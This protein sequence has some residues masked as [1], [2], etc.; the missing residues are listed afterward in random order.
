MPASLPRPA[1][2]TPGPEGAAA[3]LRPEQG[4]SSQVTSCSVA[5]SQPAVLDPGCTL[6]SVEKV[7]WKKILI[8]RATGRRHQNLW[9]WDL[10]SSICCELPGGS[11]AEGGSENH[12]RHL[13]LKS[14]LLRSLPCSDTGHV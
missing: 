5:F 9:E 1:A 8:A 3:A 11:D 10:V 7:G 12:G 4:P 13:F 14:H 6:Q 2:R